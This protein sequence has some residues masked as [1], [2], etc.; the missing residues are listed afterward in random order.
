MV[1][2]QEGE[3]SQVMKDITN[4]HLFWGYLLVQEDSVN[5]HAQDERTVT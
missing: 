4:E 5:V 1:G 2:N 3:E